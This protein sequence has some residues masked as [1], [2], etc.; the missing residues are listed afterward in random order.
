MQ[1]VESSFLITLFFLIS[2]FN[3]FHSCPENNMEADFEE[4]EDIN[5]VSFQVTLKRS[6]VDKKCHGLVRCDFYFVF[7]MV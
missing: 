4:V 7:N 6:H 5:I 1:V 2:C 3:S